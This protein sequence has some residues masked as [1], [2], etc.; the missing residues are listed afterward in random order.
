MWDHL[1]VPMLVDRRSLRGGLSPEPGRPRPCSPW[2]PSF[3]MP[4]FLLGPLMPHHLLGLDE[5]GSSYAKQC[6]ARAVVNR[7]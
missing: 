2:R 3:G 6:V 4:G 7:R 1:G 5:R